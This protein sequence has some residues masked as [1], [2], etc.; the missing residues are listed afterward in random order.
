[1]SIDLVTIIGNISRSMYPVQHLLAYFSYLTGIIFFMTALI[2]L[3]K[4]GESRGRSQE[5]LVTPIAFLLGGAALIYLPRTIT[6]LSNTT[7]GA[8]N[9]LQYTNYNPYDLYSS[10]SLIIQT[11]GLIWFIRGCVLLIGASKPGEQH[12]PKGFAFLCAGILAIN[13]QNTA[14]V[15][16]AALAYIMSLTISV[17]N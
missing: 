3:K 15:L 7:F 6:A 11:A 12:G 14:S 1:M 17:K 5:K 2:K 9:I 4:I 16:N 13:F 10:M 8:G